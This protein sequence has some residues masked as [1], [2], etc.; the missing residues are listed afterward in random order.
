[1]GCEPVGSHVEHLKERNNW[2]YKWGL[3]CHVAALCI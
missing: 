1:M 2:N 3:C